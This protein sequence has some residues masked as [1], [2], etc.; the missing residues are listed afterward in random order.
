V[1]ELTYGG[2]TSE[3]GFVVRTGRKALWITSQSI[4]GG[5][6]P[7]LINRLSSKYGLDVEVVAQTY[8]S[9]NP[10]D[11]SIASNKVLVVVSSLVGSG[12]VRGWARNFTT[13]GPP[14]PVIN[15]EYALSPDFCQLAEGGG[16]GN[17]AGLAS[18]VI[19]NDNSYLAAGLPNGSYVVTDPQEGGGWSDTVPGGIG[20]AIDEAD[21]QLVLSAVES[22]LVVENTTWAGVPVTHKAR[23]VFF[24]ILQNDTGNFLTDDGW[25]LWDATV[26]WLLPPS[27]MAESGP[28]AG[29]MTLS[30][31]SE[32][33][34]QVTDSL[35]PPVWANAPN[36]DNPQVVPTTESEK[37]FRI[38]Q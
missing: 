35:S 1:C 30:W 5:G 11:M 24:G 38:R 10:T 23:K 37:Y 31:T 33:T 8:T 34:L 3:W 19:T 15:W 16:Q 26:E 28:G 29:E 22:G 32:G 18:I 20:V 12:N 7:P 21:D 6:D 36:Q 4:P 14:V 27:V 13:E 17:N 2:V 25:K 9:A